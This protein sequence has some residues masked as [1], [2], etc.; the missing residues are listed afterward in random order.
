MCKKTSWNKESE[1]NV[2][3]NNFQN[4]IEIKI[5]ERPKTQKNFYKKIKLRSFTVEE[6]RRK[7]GKRWGGEKGQI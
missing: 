1:W 2:I 7:F 4:K 3:K 6:I 5:S